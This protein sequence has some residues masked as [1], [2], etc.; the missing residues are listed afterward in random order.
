MRELGCLNR[1]RYSK[2]NIIG[3][4]RW[5]E[6]WVFDGDLLAKCL[7]VQRGSLDGSTWSCVRRRNVKGLY[8]IPSSGIGGSL[9][10]SL[11]SFFAQESSRMPPQHVSRVFHKIKS[12]YLRNEMADHDSCVIRLA[13]LTGY[14][15][16]LLSRKLA[17]TLNR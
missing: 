5:G 4:R 16:A 7:E 2:R 9:D 8:D 10:N 1:G 14:P 3:W 13:F 6:C 17:T 12:N 15:F 11:E